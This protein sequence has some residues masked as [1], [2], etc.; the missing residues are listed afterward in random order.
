MLQLESLW[1][2]YDCFYVT[3]KKEISRDL[4]KKF[5]TYF[6][7]DPVRNLFYLLLTILQS[8]LIFLKENPKIIVTTGGGIAV[9]MSYIGKFF[10]KKIIFIESLSR[11]ENPSLTGKLLYP[12]SDL[13]LVQW[14]S[15]LKK[16]GKKAKYGGRV[17]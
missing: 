13:F 6:I 15:L 3:E 10:R 14:K 7:K 8:I 16:Y 11:V 9:P 2:K 5:K 4:P 12:I 17:L 1:K